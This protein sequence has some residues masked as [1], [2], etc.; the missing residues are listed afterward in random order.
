MQVH[1][2][3]SQVYFHSAAVGTLLKT[4]AAAVNRKRGSRRET[5][6]NLSCV[7]S[8]FIFII[9]F[10]PTLAPFDSLLIRTY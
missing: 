4:P 1:S 10:S 3:C 5:G 2:L 6:T 8:P 7:A 9:A